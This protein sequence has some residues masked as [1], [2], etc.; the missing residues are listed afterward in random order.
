VPQVIVEI[1]ELASR[2]RETPQTIEDAL[3]LLGGLGRAEPVHQGGL[4]KLQLASALP[5]GRKASHSARGHSGNLDDDNQDIG[6]A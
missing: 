1:P 5:G 2:F 3:R 4:W 6:A